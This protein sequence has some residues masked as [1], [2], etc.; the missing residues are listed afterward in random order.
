M[1]V[2]L[3]CTKNWYY[4]LVVNIYSLLRNN[5]NVKKI[6]LLLETDKIDD[7]QYLKELSQKFKVE[8]EVINI[9]KHQKDYLSDKS[10]N[11]NTIYTN[12]C[13]SRLMLA[14]FVK[15]DKVLYIDTDALV[16]KNIEY[17]WNLDIANY[18]VIGVKDYGVIACKYL[19]TLH[20][21]GRYINSGFVVFNLKKIREENI[22]KKWFNLVNT[23]YL[24]FPDQDALNIICTESE[25]YIPSIYNYGVGCMMDVF[26]I[27]MIKVVHYLGEKDPWVAD[28]ILAEYWYDVEEKFIDE[29]INK[30]GEK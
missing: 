24:K 1:I 10:P 21:K 17:V 26:N 23:K 12:M 30:K 14:D 7:V 11:T 22:V 18:Y 13:F 20:L 5:K 28:K 19:E 4:Y 2:A 3:S 27:N 8:I 16:L 6:Y 9:T 29:F 25:F 15:E